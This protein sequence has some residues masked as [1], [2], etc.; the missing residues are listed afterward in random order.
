M[1]SD[2]RSARMTAPIPAAAHREVRVG[3]QRFACG[4]RQ[5]QPRPGALIVVER[6]HGEVGV[7]LGHRE[8]TG[9][10][11]T[12]ARCPVAGQREPIAEQ[13]FEAEHVLPFHLAPAPFRIQSLIEIEGIDGDV[14]RVHPECPSMNDVPPPAVEEVNGGYR[15][16]GVKLVHVKSYRSLA[17]MRAVACAQ[18]ARGRHRHRSV[19]G[20]HSGCRGGGEVSGVVPDALGL[21]HES[22]CVGLA[23]ASPNVEQPL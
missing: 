21:G 19:P 17:F 10:Q 11:C 20:L 4:V 22:R 18:T 23:A 5:R 2:P 1:E 15:V 3:K 9:Q 7:P 13:R 8:C 14:E 12:L 16:L 6:K